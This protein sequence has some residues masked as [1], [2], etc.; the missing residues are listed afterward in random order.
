MRTHGVWIVDLEGRTAYVNSRM[1]DILGITPSDMTDQPYV[2]YVSPENVDTVKGLF[3][4]DG[5]PNHKPIRVRLRRRNG[6][7][8]WVDIIGAPMHNAAGKLLGII[9]TVNLALPPEGVSAD[10]VSGD[11]AT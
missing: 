7:A 1:A 2:K 6:S 9:G 11:T 8:V 3:E 5:Q 10:V 4:A